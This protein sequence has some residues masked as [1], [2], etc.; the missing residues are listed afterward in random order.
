MTSL[1]ILYIGAHPDD[2]GSCGGSLA[3]YAAEGARAYVACA[4]RGDGVDAKIK[5]P[6]LATRETLGQ[7]R[8]QELI[9]ACA[10]LGLQPPFFLGYQ[11]GEV[12]KVDTEAAA[13]AMAKL[14]RELKAQVVITHDPGGG[15]GHPDHLAVNKF[16]TRA[17]ELASDPAQDVGAPMF[18]PA[19]LYYTAFPR[20]FME[21]VPAF[22]ER[23]ADIRGQQLGFVGV[24][25]EDI[26]TAIDIRAHMRVKLDALSCHRTQFQMDET[27]RPKT[28]ASSA[29][30]EVR[31]ELLGHERFV[32]ARSTV[33]RD[34][35][36]ME[37]DLLAGLR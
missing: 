37:D 35:D 18:A 5:D 26:T 15:Y 29:P 25:D 17:F 1:A 12:D 31:M 22:R 33:A 24:A 30:E 28:F 8:S 32:L 3:K 10:K 7:V 19:K 9:C 4:T 11:D 36:G 6:V 20:S 34:G 13:R 16:V 27:G 2:E 21:K 23:R 14:I